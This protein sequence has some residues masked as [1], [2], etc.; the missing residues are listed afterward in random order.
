M[1]KILVVKDTY[2]H[3]VG[4]QHSMESELRQKEVKSFAYVRT[5]LNLEKQVS[6]LS[7]PG[8]AASKACFLE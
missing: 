5:L 2:S 7:A 4:T 8:T 6:S 3:L 1:T